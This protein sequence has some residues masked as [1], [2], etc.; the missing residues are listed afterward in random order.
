MSI[1]E[2]MKILIVD[3]EYSIRDSLKLFLEDFDY[4]VATVDS[5]EDALS[6]SKQTMF[7][8]AIIDLRL[9]GISGDKLIL[10]LNVIQPNMKFIIH[11][12]STEYRLPSCLENI[13]IQKAQIV[14]KPIPNLKDLITKI[15]QILNDFK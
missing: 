8:L 4:H 12:G 11:T 15:E 9:P 13:G 1:K 6:L 2:P 14:V 3:D 7:D 5:A 10:A